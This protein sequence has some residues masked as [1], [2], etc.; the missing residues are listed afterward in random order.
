MKPRSRHADDDRALSRK[1]EGARR[2][3]QNVVTVIL[4]KKGQGKS[5]LAKQQA[6][7]ALAAGRPVVVWD[8]QAEYTTFSPNATDPVSGLRRFASADPTGRGDVVGCYLA[9]CVHERRMIS[10]AIECA[11]S[12]QFAALARF[13]LRCSREAGQVLVIVDE[14]D[15]LCSPAFIPVELKALVGQ[16]RLRGIDQTYL[17]RRP[18]HV[19]RDLTAAADVEVYFRQRE[20]RDLDWLARR[21][22]TNVAERVRQL[23]E[24]QAL[25]L[26]EID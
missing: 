6:R 10:A 23:P 17:S 16:G 8:P 21:F 5:R 13:L 26:R 11:P 12:W 18:A 4:G 14:V 22:G 1:A 3:V 24:Q 7:A 20:Q 19:H 2:G 9:T 25:I 15:Q